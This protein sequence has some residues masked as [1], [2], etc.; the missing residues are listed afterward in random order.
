MIREDQ[1]ERIDTRKYRSDGLGCLGAIVLGTLTCMGVGKYSSNHQ[2]PKASANESVFIESEG[3]NYNVSFTCTYEHLNDHSCERPENIDSVRVGRADF[4]NMFYE[5][6]ATN[7]KDE[8]TLQMQQAA[9]N[10]VQGEEYLR[11]IAEKRE[12]EQ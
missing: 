3:I 9:W 4:W 7:P 12:K 6:N 5:K 8:L 2:D 1:W 11:V 10:L